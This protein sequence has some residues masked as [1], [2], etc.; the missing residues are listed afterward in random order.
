MTY[1]RDYGDAVLL[2][3]K[4]RRVFQLHPRKWHNHFYGSLPGVEVVTPE[5]F[6]SA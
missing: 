1:T 6:E 4:R 5:E 2:D 3:G